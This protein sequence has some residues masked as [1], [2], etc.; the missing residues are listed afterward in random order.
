M[1]LVRVVCNCIMSCVVRGYVVY[2]KTHLPVGFYRGPLHTLSQ[3][4]LQCAVIVR[5]S[6][7]D[8]FTCFIGP[9]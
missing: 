9:Q 4:T 6:L 5:S 7:H 3:Y 2:R 1:V 8:R